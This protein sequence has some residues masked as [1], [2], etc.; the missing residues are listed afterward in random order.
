MRRT[1]IGQDGLIDVEHIA[2]MLR[3]LALPQVDIRKVNWWSKAEQEIE[4]AKKEAAKVDGSIASAEQIFMR[5][6]ERAVAERG[7]FTRALSDAQETL[8]KS[9]GHVFT[10]METRDFSKRLIQNLITAF[11]RGERAPAALK[12]AALHGVYVSHVER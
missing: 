9:S 7:T 2:N 8:W 11:D 10:E 3:S 4:N 6:F 12:H 1:I 5:I